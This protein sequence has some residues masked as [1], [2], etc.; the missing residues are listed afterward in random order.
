MTSASSFGNSKTQSGISLSL[1]SASRKDASNSADGLLQQL[2]ATSLP[3]SKFK[4]DSIFLKSC[5]FLMMQWS[6]S[7]CVVVSFFSNSI[8]D[9][10]ANTPVTDGTTGKSFFDVCLS[11]N[12]GGV[13]VAVVLNCPLFPPFRRRSKD[14]K[15]FLPNR[16]RRANEL[17]LL[18][19]IVDS[20]IDL[21]HPSPLAATFDTIPAKRFPSRR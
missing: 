21:P 12:R 6:T 10:A 16:R 8:V 20:L 5:K 19:A 11:I 15:I 18:L 1:F 17:L 9:E 4:S 2:L 3:S 7:F 13:V 14:I